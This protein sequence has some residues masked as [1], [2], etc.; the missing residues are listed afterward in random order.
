MPRRTITVTHI[1]QHVRYELDHRL[2][3]DA[4]PTGDLLYTAHAL[5]QQLPKDHLVD[6]EHERYV[7]IEKMHRRG[8][9]LMFELSAGPLG[10]AGEVRDSATHVVEHEYG[11]AAARTV[12]LRAMLVVPTGS[13]SALFFIE[14]GSSTADGTALKNR[15]VKALRYWHP[16]LTV[17][18][19]RV[20]E[21]EA[22]LE[23]AQLM[24][25]TAMVYGHAP[26][27]EEHIEGLPK[28]L[29]QL[30]HAILP[31]KGH[32]VLPR[33]I[34]DGLVERSIDRSALFGISADEDVEDVTVRMTNNGRE[35]TFAL[36]AERFPTLRLMLTDSGEAEPTADGFRD[37]V[38][39][40]T[41]E[42]FQGVSADWNTAEAEGEW[43]PEADE[44]VVQIPPA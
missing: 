39:A 36:G 40:E 42:L 37:F 26:D 30:Q 35:K 2:K 3:L 32:K 27:L 41:T 28:V 1:Y 38:L 23:G 14:H 7:S 4:L 44:V 16:D 10:E 6:T 19:D 18:Q 15:L 13:R 24:R 12:A 20:V 25:A 9:T 43:P 21:A 17:K 34:Y 8:R 29:G 22:W 31:E 5:F 11:T 33:A